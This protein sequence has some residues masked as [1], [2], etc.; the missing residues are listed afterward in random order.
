[1]QG[2][3]VDAPFNFMADAFYRKYEEMVDHCEKLA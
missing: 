3:D 1:M 2:T